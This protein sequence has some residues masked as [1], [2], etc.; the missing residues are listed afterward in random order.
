MTSRPV[1]PASW[2][3]PDVPTMVAGTPKHVGTAECA[4][5]ATPDTARSTT[6]KASRPAIDRFTSRRESAKRGFELERCSDGSW[7]GGEPGG[8]NPVRASLRGPARA[9]Q[10]R[11]DARLELGRE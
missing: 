3:G 6:E 7:G 4:G 2:S 5:A 8:V 9:A 10:D 11:C 1:V